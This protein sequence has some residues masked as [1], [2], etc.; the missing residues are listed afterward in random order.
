M[1]NLEIEENYINGKLNGNVKEYFRDKLIY[2][3][4]YLNGKRHG[5]GREFYDK[6]ILKFEGE[7]LNDKNGKEKDMI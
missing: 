5:K 3:G 4:E 6:E 1:I 7:Y 2:E